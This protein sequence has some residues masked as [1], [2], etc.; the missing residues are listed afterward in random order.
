[1]ITEGGRCFKQHVLVLPTNPG[2]GFRAA[3]S[4]A[5]LSIFI[6]VLGGEEQVQQPDSA[7]TDAGDGIKQETGMGWGEGS[8]ILEVTPRHIPPLPPATSILAM[9]RPWGAGKAPPEPPCHDLFAKSPSSLEA[10]HVH[11][12]AM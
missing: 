2:T 5:A 8:G 4:G 9:A 6:C 3:R 1:M 12:A 10:Q 11:G 7:R